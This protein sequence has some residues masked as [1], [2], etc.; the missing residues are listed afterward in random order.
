MPVLAV[1]SDIHGNLNA[2]RA[3][4]ADCR[5]RHV[6]RIVC[7]G[8]I[9]G[10]G[11]RPR[12]CLRLVRKSCGIVVRGNHDLAASLSPYGFGKIARGAILWTKRQLRPRFF[13]GL[14]RR[15]DWGWLAS[16]PER[17]Q[18]QN[19]LFV[20]ASPYSPMLDYLLPECG[21]TDTHSAAGR[22]I[23]AFS[24]LEGP[25]FA[26]HTHMAGLF[27]SALRFS[28]PDSLGGEAYLSKDAC[29]VN[30]GSVGQ[31]RDNDPRA[32]YVTVEDERIC[33]H[34]VAYDVEDTVERILA[35]P[36]LDDDLGLRLREGR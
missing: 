8:D 14:T 36:E 30:V 24:Q 23:E 17:H 29:I 21:A 26:G 11:P 9:V 3:V 35:V 33:F 15:R 32:S 13:S 22:L 28:S 10:Y 20:H 19:R 18:E 6:D 4:L 25:C 5:E 27:D 1:I 16:L 31:P 2:L 12:Q 34:R 7:L